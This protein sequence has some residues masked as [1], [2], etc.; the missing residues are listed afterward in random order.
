VAFPSKDYQ[1]KTF[2]FNC[3]SDFHDPFSKRGKNSTAQNWHKA[4][5]KSAAQ[6]SLRSAGSRSIVTIPAKDW[7]AFEAWAARPA[8]RIPALDEL[9]RRTSL[10]EQ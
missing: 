1:L 2:V 9:L 4:A 10:R 3:L 8:E 7:E 5:Q 6:N